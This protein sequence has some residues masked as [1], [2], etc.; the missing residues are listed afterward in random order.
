MAVV[1]VPGFLDCLQGIGNNNKKDWCYLYTAQAA[2]YKIICLFPSM[3][4]L[5]DLKMV[6]AAWMS[7]HHGDQSGTSGMVS[8]H[9][10]RGVHPNSPLRWGVLRWAVAPRMLVSSQKKSW[11][12]W[13]VLHAA[14]DSISGNKCVQ[15]YQ[16]SKLWIWFWCPYF[17]NIAQEDSEWISVKQGAI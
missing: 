15:K 12:A 2:S 10:G 7:H 6:W 16:G 4:I 3:P 8:A 5:L 11:C 9:Q 13:T 1:L 17:H 14:A